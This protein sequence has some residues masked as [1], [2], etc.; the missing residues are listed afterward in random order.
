MST[1]RVPLR[2]WSRSARW[3]PR[4]ILRPRDEAEV[5]EALRACRR[6]GA[7]LRVVGGAHSFS[8]LVAADDVLMTLDGHQGLV[9]V[10]AATGLVTL[11]GGTR[12]HRIADLLA[13]HGLALAV[14]GDID[15]Q[16][17]AGAIQTGTHGTGAAF[18]GFAGMVRALRIALPGGEVVDASPAHE[19]ALFEAARLGLGSIGV[20]LEVTLQCVPSYCLSLR[21]STEPI[22]ATVG[23]FLADTDAHDH[24]EF[25]WFPSTRRATVRTST[26]LAADTVRAR[27]GVLAESLQREAL[28]NGAFEVLCRAAAAVPALSRPVA[29]V[30]SR[31]FAG[32]TMVDRSDRVFVAPRRVRFHET[33]WAL[34]AERFEEAFAAL[35]AALRAQRIAVTFPL[36]F[37][38]VAADD[39]WLSTAHG[40]DSVYIAAHRHHLERAEPYLHLVQ[41]T[42]APFEA[43][44]HWGKQHWLGAVELRRLYP[45]FED[46]RAVRAHADPDGM[47]LTPYL[48]H[49]L[50]IAPRG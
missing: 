29:D 41:R 27:R 17:I 48:R 43:R 3:S 40:R 22:D 10:D 30:S 2:N 20:I 34:P 42:L 15:H 12:L 47:L 7:R 14:M 44:P 37:R 6:T 19:P 39:V 1:P 21:E 13:P 9:A 16:S 32:P 4:E 24:H 49:L 11:R 26:R 23:G 45:R 8:P 28:D 38:R 46:F 31:F 18:T 25:F 50:G 33:E 35:D 5:L 36:E